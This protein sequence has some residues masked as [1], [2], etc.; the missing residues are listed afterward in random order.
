ME[1]K[2]AED[3]SWLQLFIKN[4]RNPQVTATG[5]RNTRVVCNADRRPF[6]RSYGASLPS[7]LTRVLS[8]ALGYSP[9][10]PESVCGTDQTVQCSAAFL[11]SLGLLG[12]EPESSPHHLS[13]LRANVCPCRVLSALPTGLNWL[14]TARRAYPTPSPLN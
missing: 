8:R 13:E 2:S 11:G 7:S 4:S 5:S 3:T 10:P 6:S 1:L 9:R 12:C 14:P